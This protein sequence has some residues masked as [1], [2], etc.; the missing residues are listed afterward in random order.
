MKNDDKKQK[1]EEHF[2][3]IM[4]LRKFIRKQG[5]RRIDLLATFNFEMQPY[6]NEKKCQGWSVYMDQ[7]LEEGNP[8]DTT[9][10]VR[11][12]TEPE[13]FH[14]KFLSEPFKDENE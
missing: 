4:N 11:A 3:K 6:L 10:L 1:V 14:N 8:S 9:I 7:T 13:D 12:Y 2:Q 5:L